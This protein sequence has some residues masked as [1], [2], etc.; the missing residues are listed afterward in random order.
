MDL[1]KVSSGK[2]DPRPALEGSLWSPL[3]AVLTLY[4]FLSNG[5]IE[6]ENKK[7]YIYIYMKLSIYL[8]L[9]IDVYIWAKSF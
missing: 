3:F 7:I 6:K 4:P 8:Y 1:V 9:D 5:A 2:V